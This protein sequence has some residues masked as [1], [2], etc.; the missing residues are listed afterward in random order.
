MSDLDVFTLKYVVETSSAARTLEVFDKKMQSVE[1]SS[2]RAAS[3]FGGFASKAAQE[4]ES[5]IP[6]ARGAATAIAAIG[7]AAGPAAAALAT[8]AVAVTSFSAARAQLNR[9]RLDAQTLGL[10]GV[11]LEDQTRAISLGSRGRVSREQAVGGMMR[12]REI[13]R[14]AATDP[15]RMGHDAVMMRMLGLNIGA[16]QSENMTAFATSLHGKS[17]E[18]IDGIAQAA[19]FSRDW[20]EA[21]AKLGPKI[22]DMT[23]MTLG[24]IK[25]R[26]HAERQ[27]DDYNK[28]QAQLGADWQQMKISLGQTLIPAFDTLIGMA[29]GLGDALNWLNKNAFVP[30]VNE[31]EDAASKTS[32][33][34]GGAVNGFFDTPQA[35][36]HAAYEAEQQ[37]K[38][39]AKAAQEAAEKNRDVRAKD[40]QNEIANQNADAFSLAIAQFTASVGDFAGAAPSVQEVLA[41]WAGSAGAAAGLG[42]SGSASKGGASGSGAT[43]GMRNNNPG[44]LEYGEFAKAHGATGSDGRF[45]VFPTMQAGVSAQENLLQSNYIG[46]GL[47]TPRQIINKYAPGNENDTGQ[48]L[49]YLKSQGF[50]PDQP[51]KNLPAFAAA[52]RVHESGEAARNPGAIGWNKGTVREMETARGLASFLGVPVDQLLRGGVNQRDIGIAVGTS[53]GKI[54]NEILSL[55]GGISSLNGKTDPQSVSQL[56]KL[57][58][59]LRSDQISLQ[60]LRTY[61]NKIIDM[62]AA[63]DGGYRN[64]AIENQTLSFH[65]TGTDPHA[66]ADQIEKTLTRHYDDMLS[67]QA[68]GRKS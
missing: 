25:A 28:A 30:L 22:G 24:E 9:Q 19:G 12:L 34:V 53:K 45:A 17:T 40:R 2:D 57:Q 44:N 43:R 32:K 39:D 55:Q 49:S 29:T 60:N 61:G 56:S 1:K 4:L 14:G 15:S 20:L 65:I 52:M 33:A 31:I 3:S 46:K 48:Y 47:T 27:L 66:I 18:Q 41:A 35:R 36:Q 68:S 21:L 5:V 8:L 50:D 38:L 64:V 11:R 63:G 10:S 67:N 51:V 42:G 37:K 7:S 58:Q 26:E 62:G 16:S 59:K 54:S 6:G 23:Q 13:A